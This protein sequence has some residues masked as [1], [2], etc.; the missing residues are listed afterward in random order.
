MPRNS[1]HLIKED[2][3]AVEYRAIILIIAMVGMLIVFILV[4]YLFIY[5]RVLRS[6]ATLQEGTAIIGSGNLDYRIEETSKDEIG[7]LAQRF[8]PDECQPR[9]GAGI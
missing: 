5:W 3:R 6:V 1:L 9:N 8:Q 4:N 7:D 2:T